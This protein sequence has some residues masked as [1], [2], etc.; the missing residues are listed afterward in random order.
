[1]KL[2]ADFLPVILFFVAYK[3]AEIYV[4]TGVAIAAAIAHLTYLRASRQT[5]KPVHWIGLGFILLFGSLTILL[6]DPFFIKVKWTIFYGL[7]GTLILLFTA[8]GRNPLKSVLGN[9]IE[10]PAEAWHKFSY[11]WGIFFALLA[12]LNQYFAV[13]L[14]LDAWVNVKVWGGMAATILFAVGQAIWL[15]RYFPDEP[16][17]KAAAEPAKEA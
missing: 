5:I 13:T 6:K 11:S 14:S 10:L 12:A 4:A 3:V 7:L 15:A 8:L 16:P 1:M 17:V 9:E 2:L